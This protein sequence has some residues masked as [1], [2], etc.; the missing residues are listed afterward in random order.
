MN[1]AFIVNAC[2]IKIWGNP[3]N[4]RLN[5]SGGIAQRVSVQHGVGG[6]RGTHGV[7]RG[8]QLSP[9]LWSGASCDAGPA[10][11]KGPIAPRCP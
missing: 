1:N 8:V 10:R 4:L 2:Q 3:V 5:M 11:R 6:I 7:G 9:G